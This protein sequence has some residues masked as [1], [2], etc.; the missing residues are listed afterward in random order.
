M[1]RKALILHTI[2]PLSF[3]FLYYALFKEGSYIFLITH[4]FI[5]LPTPSIAVPKIINYHFCDCM[6]GY[7]LYMMLYLITYSHRRSL[8]FSI[9][10]IILL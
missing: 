1:T 5:N 9:P 2:I 10:L 8:L 3:G 7:S 4:K 6:W